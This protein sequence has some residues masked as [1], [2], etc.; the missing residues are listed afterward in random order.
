MIPKA[1][2]CKYVLCLKVQL[3]RIE[4]GLTANELVPPYIEINSEVCK[5]LQWMI[6]AEKNGEQ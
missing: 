2:D 5:V 1:N 3:P 4:P 6:V